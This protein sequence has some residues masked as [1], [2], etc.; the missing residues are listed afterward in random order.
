MLLRRYD[1]FYKS[2]K[3]KTIVLNI[4]CLTEG[5]QY[6]NVSQGLIRPFLQLSPLVRLSQL[7]SQDLTM[8]DVK[9]RFLLY[10]GLVLR[11]C[12]FLFSCQ[13]SLSKEENTKTWITHKTWI[14]E[15]APQDITKKKAPPGA[16]E[17]LY[18]IF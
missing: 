7:T 9:F 11:I 1:I 8:D 18:H 2:L 6:V 12:V 3:V 14:T 16:R 13:T 10:S 5:D 4:V 17:G 15:R